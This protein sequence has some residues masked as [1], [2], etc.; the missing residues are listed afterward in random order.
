MIRVGWDSPEIQTSAPPSQR[1]P[2]GCYF[3]SEH[4]NSTWYKQLL[5]ICLPSGH[6]ISLYQLWPW[7][8][9]QAW[10]AGRR[11]GRWCSFTL[12]GWGVPPPT[13]HAKGVSSLQWPDM[14]HTYFC[15]NLVTMLWFSYLAGQRV[16]YFHD[17]VALQL[18]LGRWVTQ[19][20]GGHAGASLS[21]D[22][23]Q[24]PSLP[25]ALVNSQNTLW[26]F[27][28]EEWGWMFL[29]VVAV[30]APT[31]SSQRV[32]ATGNGFTEGK[33]QRLQ[34]WWMRGQWPVSPA[35]TCAKCSTPSHT[36]S[37]SPDWRDRDLM[38][39]PLRG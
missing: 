23:G 19:S 18:P 10:E 6:G 1:K 31:P 32:S 8:G 21:A 14:R 7:K 30:T 20:P 26:W 13:P 5:W 24:C 22:R 39:G 33:Q 3:I 35:W 2:S 16:P 37:L 4:K 17:L 12:L 38:N 25:A 11:V 36:T 27:T 28:R 15:F 9:T 29:S 34:W